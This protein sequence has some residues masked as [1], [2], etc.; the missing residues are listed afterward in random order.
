MAGWNTNFYLLFD[1][2][3]DFF[4][5][6]LLVVLSPASHT[7]SDWY[8]PVGDGGSAYLQSALSL[9]PLFLSLL[10]YSSLWI[11]LYCPPW[12]LSICTELKET[13][14]L[15]LGSASLHLSLETL[16]R[17]KLRGKY[18]FYLICCSLLGISFLHCLFAN[19]WKAFFISFFQFL[20]FG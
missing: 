1:S 7:C 8:S 20:S 12:K 9:S 15:H 17:C 6:S 16:S 2:S 18:R 11:K 3:V 10:G 4:A 19:T 13:N 14:S 5:C